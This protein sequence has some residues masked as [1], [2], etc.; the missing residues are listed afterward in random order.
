M[1]DVCLLQGNARKDKALREAE[2]EKNELQ[3]QLAAMAGEITLERSITTQQA[4]KGKELHE[5]LGAY[6]GK[7]EA[8]KQQ[9]AASAKIE[10]RLTQSIAALANSLLQTESAWCNHSPPVDIILA[11]TIH[12]YQRWIYGHVLRWSLPCME[13][14]FCLTSCAGAPHAFRRRTYPRTAQ[15]VPSMPGDLRQT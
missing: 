15:I 8:F 6:R 11:A 4:E 10:K 1:G 14:V 9:L 5:K 3:Q 2:Q 13:F 12:V 7:E